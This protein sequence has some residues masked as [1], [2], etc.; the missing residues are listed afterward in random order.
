MDLKSLQIWVPIAQTE[1]IT[2]FN[3]LQHR[4]P[5]YHNRNMCSLGK[6]KG[7]NLSILI[8]IEFKKDILVSN[9]KKETQQVYL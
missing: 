1:N 6:I 2:K 4:L 5:Q 3:E 7:L 9:F 8:Q